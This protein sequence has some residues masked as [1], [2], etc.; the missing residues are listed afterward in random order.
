MGRGRRVDRQR[1]D[2][3]DIH[4]VRDQLQARDE[5][6]GG[7]LAALERE[8]EDRARP[9]RHVAVGQSLALLTGQGRVAHPFD[10]RMVLQVGGHGLGVGA[11]A[12]HPQRQ[13]LDAGEREEGVH[14]REAGAE[15]AQAE[16]AAGD[17]EADLGEAVA[18]DQAVIVRPGLVD[19]VVAR[20]LRLPVEGA[21]VADHAADHLPRA[22]EELRGRVDDDVGAVLDRAD[23][24]GRGQGVVD[25]ERQAVAL[26][27]RRDTL[28]IHHRGAGVDDR[29]ADD[30]L[31]L[32]RD[33]RLERLRRQV[34][35]E[36]R[37]QVVAAFEPAH[38]AE[39]AAEQARRGDVGV[40]RPHQRHHHEQH[41][42][43]PGGDGH[44]RLGAL[45][46][47]D[48]TLQRGDRRVRAARVGE[49]GLAHRE[50]VGRLLGGI[51]HEAVGEVDRLRPR[52]CGG[53]G[54]GARMDRLRGEAEG[55]WLGGHGGT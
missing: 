53:I 15:V 2:L 39:R 25:H 27:D 33:R 30:R 3:A 34:G 16:Q 8:G 28:E 48:A 43:L 29:L 9:L 17:G 1:F 36:V 20:P 50:D 11:V 55:L 44:R 52:A 22:A 24:G 41:R 47:G 45:Q 35:G 12:L 51:E 6:Q 5:A 38:Q 7:R 31:G 26:G 19:E 32:R 23:Q 54:R 42:R 4:E 46:R 49:A 13:R 21:G 14:R 37:R 18:D 10:R 40:A